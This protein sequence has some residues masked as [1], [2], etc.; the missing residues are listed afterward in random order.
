MNETQ[1]SKSVKKMQRDVNALN[2]KLAEHA[3]DIGEATHGIPAFGQAGF[4][5]FDFYEKNKALF[6]DRYYINNVDVNELTPGCY[7][8][9]QLA[10]IP[11]KAEK[12]ALALINVTNYGPGRK[13]IIYRQAYANVTWTKTIHSP[14][15]N[16]NSKGWLKQ[17]SS[18]VLWQGS[19]SDV[20]AVMTLADSKSN[21]DFLQIIAE[22]I[23]HNATSQTFTTSRGVYA[24]SVSNIPDSEDINISNTEIGLDF[25]SSQTAVRITENRTIFVSAAHSGVVAGLNGSITAII[26]V[27][28]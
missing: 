6:V 8:G 25:G 5:P 18:N 26:G 7:Y 28:F 11:D 14:G 22:G 2:A 16:P 10:G 23:G 4:M 3:G 13:E 9:S 21:Y 17:T 12:S 27:N 19:A 1:L 15:T 24:V 20:G